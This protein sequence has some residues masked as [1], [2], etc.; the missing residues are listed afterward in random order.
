MSG[1]CVAQWW[2]A[3]QP[4]QG[5]GSNPST[6]SKPKQK[7]NATLNRRGG[8]T[9]WPGL[10]EGRSGGSSCACQ[11]SAHGSWLQAPGYG[12]SKGSF[13]QPTSR[14]TTNPLARSGLCASYFDVQVKPRGAWATLRSPHKLPCTRSSFH[15]KTSCHSH[16]SGCQIPI[17]ESQGCGQ[18]DLTADCGRSLGTEH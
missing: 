6:K 1:V 10:G 18:S 15:P 14:G 3:A 8:S 17:L 7:G 4:E 12:L 13:H 2:N 11:S 9:G 5:S 16:R